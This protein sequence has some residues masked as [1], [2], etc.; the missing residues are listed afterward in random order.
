MDRDQGLPHYGRVTGVS[1]ARIQPTLRPEPQVPAA[2]PRGVASAWPTS[3]LEAYQTKTYEPFTQPP[4]ASVSQPYYFA[5]QE[6]QRGHERPDTHC[7]YCLVGKAHTRLP[8]DPTDSVFCTSCRQPY[9]FCYVHGKA[10][11]GMGLSRTDPALRQCQCQRGQEF[12]GQAGWQSC[13]HS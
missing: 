2:G 5:T 13:F 9:H 12:L 4:T 6:P 1:T 10:L 8:H 3:P 11:S 7:P